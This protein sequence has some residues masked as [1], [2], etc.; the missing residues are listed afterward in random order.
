MTNSKIIITD[1]DN[2]IWPWLDWAPDAYDAMV[3]YLSRR[4]GI[5][6]DAIIASF[7]PH[8]ITKESIEYAAVI[9][10]SNSFSQRAER[11]SLIGGAR[12]AFGLV[13]KRG[14]RLYD[15]VEETLR[16]AKG[17][18]I[19]LVALTD[20]PMVHATMRLRKLGVELIYD[21]LVALPNPM[22]ASYPQRV[23]RKIENGEYEPLIESMLVPKSKPHTPLEYVLGMSKEDIADRVM[24]VGDSP[25][26]MALAT[27]YGMTG[28]FAKYGISPNHAAL[29]AQLA[30]YV[31]DEVSAR[32]MGTGLFE[33]PENCHAI[34][35]FTEVLEYAA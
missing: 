32:N 26:D 28:L 21:K 17:R 1:L 14:L 23:Q 25:K 31:S 24:M 9:Q 2:T 34:D 16:A 29:K 10:S 4:T 18:G 19:K 33:L 22:G 30:K 15:G 12:A 3:D 6:K 13:R 8:Y 27:R 35:S 7:K 11:D 20:A 5:D